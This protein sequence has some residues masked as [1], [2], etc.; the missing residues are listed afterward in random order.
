MPITPNQVRSQFE[1]L[2][3]SDNELKKYVEFDP[4][5]STALS[6]KFKF[7]LE[8]VEAAPT[9]NLF[10][11]IN[12]LAQKRRREKYSKKIQ[13][14]FNGVKIVSEGDSWFQFP[15]LLNDVIDQIF[16]EYAI[17]SLDAAGDTLENMIN[18][19][20]YTDAIRSENPAIFLF[21]GGG[22][23]MAINYG[24]STLIRT[25]DQ[26]LSAEGYPNAAFDGF[27][28]EITNLY[29]SLFS[30]LSSEFP[31]LKIL[32]H[33]YDYVI[34][35]QFNIVFGKPMSDLGITDKNLQKNIMKVIIDRINIAQIN[36][37]Q[38]F[39]NVH[40]VDCRNA[41]GSQHW[42]DELH[43]TN[44]GFASVAGRFRSAIEK[45]V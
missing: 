2:N 6:P 18:R 19:N 3:I 39:P 27:V 40:H 33:G 28:S 37:V 9:G 14:G 13:N 26:T 22:N 43:P 42:F 10:G 5:N 20:E 17:L 16:D 23:D 1:D 44:S 4:V 41:V 8:N 29:Q 34:P 35:R 25:F 45:V 24:L 30:S 36:L 12:N 7:N 15:I 31:N 38:D 21:S 11:D 32:C